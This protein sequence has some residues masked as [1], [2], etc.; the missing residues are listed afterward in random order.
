MKGMKQS[1]WKLRLEYGNHAL[2]QVEENPFVQFSNWF[3]EALTC[4]VM[5]PNG[6]TLSTVSP[7]GHPSSR[8]VLFKGVDRGGFLFFTGYA[9]R[10]AEQMDV[11][12][13]VALTFWWKEIF[14]QVNI[15]GRVEKVSRSISR[16]YF[17][18]RPKGAQIATTVFA[19]STPIVTREELTDMF[20]ALKKQY[21][22]K[23][24]PCPMNWGGYRVIPHRFEF[25]QGRENRLHD[26]FLY[27]KINDHWVQSRL[28][29]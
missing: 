24:V 13:S 14:R 10:K 16:T 12:S 20:G 4:E 2:E 29:P 22:K 23:T 8:T 25:W 21:A 5:E 18:S 27:A 19:Q 11:N 1:S 7:L 15:E 26:R 28:S 9:S 3:D 6:M 17:A